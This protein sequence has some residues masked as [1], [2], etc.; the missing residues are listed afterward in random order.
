MTCMPGMT[1]R[2]LI[3][4]RTLADA[5]AEELLDG[6]QQVWR[7][8]LDVY[9]HTSQCYRRSMVP[10]HLSQNLIYIPDLVACALLGSPT[11][12]LA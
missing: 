8:M 12:K 6:Y 2:Y 5:T 11:E 9:V 3:Q 4:Q 7:Y 1:S 10:L